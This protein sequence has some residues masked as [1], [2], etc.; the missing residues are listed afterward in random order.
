MLDANATVNEGAF[1]T[2]MS[3]HGLIDL[4]SEMNEGTAPRTYINGPNRLDYIL[5]QEELKGVVAKSGSLESHDG[6]SLSDHTLQFIDLKCSDLFRSTKTNPIAT[7]EREF[8]MNE[9]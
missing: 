9:L 1:D 7:Y 8:T 2:F 5:G 4:I 6:V 3:S